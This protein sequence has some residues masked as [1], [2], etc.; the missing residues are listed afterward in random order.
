M[1]FR[2]KATSDTQ[3]INAGYTP[4]AT[5]D[6]FNNTLASNGYIIDSLRAGEVKFV[7]K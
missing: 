1:N 7:T 4:Q 3:I 5:V 2:T 6:V